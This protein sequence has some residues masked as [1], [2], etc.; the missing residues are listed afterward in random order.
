MAQQPGI[1]IT[2]T[3]LEYLVALHAEAFD[4]AMADPRSLQRPVGTVIAEQL[5]RIVSE[6]MRALDP[7]F[8]DPA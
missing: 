2:R 6:R 5:H 8:Y 4:T 1:T 7:E 3:E